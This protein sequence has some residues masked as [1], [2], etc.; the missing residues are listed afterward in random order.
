M[1]NETI[2]ENKDTSTLYKPLISIMGIVIIILLWE[3]A[4]RITNM[5]SYILPAPS[6]VLIALIKSSPLIWSHTKI[7]L[8]ES[9]T[10][11]TVA[12]VFSFLLVFAM[13]NIPSVKEMIYPVLFISQTVPIITVAPLFIVWFGYGLLPKII[14]VALVCFFPIAVS[15]IGG[16]ES[17]D[18]EMHDLLKCMGANR[19]QIFR[20]VKLPGALPSLFSGLKIAA[21][22]SITGAVIGEWLGAKAGLGEFMRRSMHSFAVDRTFAAILV[23]SLLSLGI[24]RIIT[25]LEKKLMPWTELTEEI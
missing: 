14:I 11:F 20:T 5:P 4:V 17:T 7:T 19:M 13:D 21:A 3:G 18:K 2:G 1:K 8:Y 12:F 10:G 6:R 22:Y 15:L 24:F 23:V 25:V 16:L 9:M